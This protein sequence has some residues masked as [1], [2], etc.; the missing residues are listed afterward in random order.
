MKNVLSY[1]RLHLSIEKIKNIFLR[2]IKLQKKII[3]R[4]KINIINFLFQIII[5]IIVQI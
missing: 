2:L 1:L 3:D 4:M 5:I